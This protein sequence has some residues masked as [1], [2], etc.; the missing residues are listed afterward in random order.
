VSSIKLTTCTK[1]AQAVDPYIEREWLLVVIDCILRREEAYRH[2]LFNSDLH[3]LF[4]Y[5]RAFQFGMAWSILDAYLGWET[6]RETDPTRTSP[7]QDYHYIVAIAV[8]SFL[9]LLLQWIVIS[10]AL[11]KTTSRTSK[12]VYFALLLPSGFSV[13]TILIIIWENTQ[14]VRLLGAL[15]IAYWQSVALTVLSPTN[16]PTVIAITFL[17]RIVWKLVCSL[18]IQ[19]FPCVGL[20]LSLA[21]ILARQPLALCLA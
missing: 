3:I 7:L 10:F 21:S 13:V 1:C 14:T 19:P 15:L 6:V 17:V 5:P 2:V 4:S 8:S 9:G 12:Q 20:E 18:V 11:G 16:T